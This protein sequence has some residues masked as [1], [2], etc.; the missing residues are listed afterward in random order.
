MSVLSNLNGSSLSVLNNNLGNKF[1]G[2]INYLNNFQDSGII[3]FCYN[4]GTLILYLNKNLEEIYVPIE[5]LRKGDLVKSYL[6]GYRKIEDIVCNKTNNDVD[7]L[8]ECMYKMEK[9]DENNLIE[10]LIVTGGHSI[11]VDDLGDYKEEND[12]LFNGE[13]LKIDDKYLLLA[14]VSNDFIK[15]Q[16]ND[17]YTYYHFILENNGN[18]NDRY[19]IWANGILSETPSKNFFMSMFK[20]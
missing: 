19:G 13:T 16:N 11:L 14:A 10:D 3:V 9:T 15:L 1:I 2:Q 20:N 5:N 12:R 17:E 4:K 7:S 6:H 8:L 18:D